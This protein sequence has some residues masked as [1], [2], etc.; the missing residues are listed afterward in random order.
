M[1]AT[2]LTREG[3][4]GRAAQGQKSG[5]GGGGGHGLSRAEV[6]IRSERVRRGEWGGGGL[7]SL[8]PLYK[9]H[10]LIKEFL[11]S[12]IVDPNLGRSK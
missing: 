6:K 7:P 1:T 12:I 10:C 4:M 9:T 8:I 5:G 11:L 2:Q 3:G